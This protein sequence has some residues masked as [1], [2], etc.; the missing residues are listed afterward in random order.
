[1]RSGGETDYDGGVALFDKRHAMRVGSAM[2]V[3]AAACGRIGYD[4]RRS[5]DAATVV[6]VAITSDAPPIDAPAVC[7]VDALEIAPGSTVCI[8]IAQR[9]SDPWT[10]AKSICEGLGRRLCA[11]A[12]WLAGCTNQPTL[13]NMVGDDYEW[14]A[15]EAAGIAQKRGAS[16]CEDSSS[17][18]VTDPYGYRCCVDKL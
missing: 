2:L 12:E 13:M 4:E 16:A 5:V 7:P 17:H 18:S 14:V 8:E 15:E 10:T 1:M 11:D 6:D 3:L 9:G